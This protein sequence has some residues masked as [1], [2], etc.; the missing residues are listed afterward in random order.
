M[1]SYSN[2]KITSFKYFEINQIPVKILNANFL[3]P[4]AVPNGISSAS[5]GYFDKNL[6]KNVNGS[7]IDVVNT[8][9]WR[10]KIGG[11]T[12]EVPGLFLKEFNLP[13]GQYLQNLSSLLENALNVTQDQYLDPYALLYQGSTSLNGVPNCFQYYIPHI[14]TANSS[15]RGTIKN[16]WSPQEALIKSQKVDNF[17]KGLTNISRFVTPGASYEKTY[18][19]N[20]SSPKTITVAFPLY[21]TISIDSAIGNFSFVSLLEFQNLK[22]RTSFATYI[23]P[24]VYTVQSIGIGGIYMPV[25]YISNLDIKSIGTTRLMSGIDY[26]IGSSTNGTVIPE[27]Y[28]VEITFTELLPESANIMNGALGGDLVNV[29]NQLPNPNIFQTP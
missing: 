20:E 4:M 25:A 8:L 3:V 21:N 27:A 16:T 11:Y 13:Y 5:D 26:G 24:K 28:R 12:G 6:N 15:I 10:N 7:Y 29:I 14:I 9:P 17:I 22:T 2:K 18:T 23:P 1:A 19:Y